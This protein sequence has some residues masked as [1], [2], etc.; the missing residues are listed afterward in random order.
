MAIKK[1]NLNLSIIIPIFN[2]AKNIKILI[3]RIYNNLKNI[4]HKK[5]KN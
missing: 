5:I 2:E 3:P 4:K 1:N